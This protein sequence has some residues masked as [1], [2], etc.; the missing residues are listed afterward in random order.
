M[1]ARGQLISWRR[2]QAGERRKVDLEGKWFCRVST[3]YPFVRLDYYY[4]LVSRQCLVSLF[5]FYGS[6]IAILVFS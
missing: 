5:P 6:Q 3:Q 1:K 2:E 4:L